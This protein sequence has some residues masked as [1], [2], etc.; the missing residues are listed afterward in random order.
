ML[1]NDE[2][3]FAYF[4]K[5]K[6]TLERVR[7][8]NIYSKSRCA[9]NLRGVGP[10]YEGYVVSI[11][12]A[13]ILVSSD[14]KIQNNITAT[15]EKKAGHTLNLRNL[16]KNEQY[17][18]INDRPEK[19]GDNGEALFNYIMEN[20]SEEIKK[21]T[22]FVINKN[23]DDFRRMKYKS[24]IIDFQSQEHLD[25]FLNAKI[26]YS[27]HNAVRF[28]YPFDVSKYY[29]YADLLK[30]KFVWLQHG[31]TKDDISNEANKLNT[32]D[33]AVI[34]SSKWEYEE[35]MRDEY[36]YDKEDVILS[37][38]ARFDNLLD[39]KEKKIIVAPTWRTELV[40][41]IL[42]TGHN[43][44]KEGFELSDFYKNFA[45]FLKDPRL[46][47]LLESNGYCLKFV[48]HSGFTC[49][50]HLF[51]SI[52][53]G[54]NDT[55]IEFVNMNVF[56]YHD[57]FCTSSLFITDYSS[58]AF[59]FAYLK[60]PVI[61]FQFD[62]DTFFEKHYHKSDWEYRENGF[63]PVVKTVDELLDEIEKC[64]NKKCELD[65]VYLDRINEAFAYFD[66]NN[67]KRIMDATRKWL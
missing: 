54:I 53:E 12:D 42:N 14:K 4:D 49:Y 46:H 59:D 30:Y 47:D 58:T 52:I 63:G 2:Y 23:C 9:A 60:K 24:N 65:K 55:N 7:R 62:E 35:F 67:C 44:P 40:G 26:I 19:A 5:Q 28:I 39:R 3:Y 22:F 38:F 48:L 36:L 11:F 15:L 64:L 50:E 33:D 41:R 37:G 21:N 45:Q 6:N 43:A 31:V 27:S 16:K 18:L 66:Q 61:Y 20:E 8:N 1:V 56:S 32:L 17:I 10:V 29:C 25:K 57:A 51:K 34:T 13:R